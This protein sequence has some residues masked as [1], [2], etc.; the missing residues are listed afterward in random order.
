MIG[1]KRKKLKELSESINQ[2]IQRITET[3]EREAAFNR[4]K[5]D[6]KMTMAG[7]QTKLTSLRKQQEN[8][9]HEIS[10]LE[11]NAKFGFIENQ[12][13]DMHINFMEKDSQAQDTSS[14]NKKL[15]QEIH[16][17]KFQIDEIKNPR[18]DILKVFSNI[19]TKKP[20]G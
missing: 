14:L 11:E 19:F 10:T 17:L 15:H 7:M 2:E 18:T 13:R 4:K 12:L 20:L 9:T 5:K 6:E 1:E 3:E 8:Y 16:E